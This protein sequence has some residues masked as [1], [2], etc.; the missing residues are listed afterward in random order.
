MDGYEPGHIGKTMEKVESKVKCSGCGSAYKL[1]IP[2][3][4]KPVNFKCKKCGKVLKI[5]AKGGSGNSERSPQSEPPPAPPPEPPPGSDL[6]DMDFGDGMP[7]FETSQLPDEPDYGGTG[8]SYQEPSQPPMYSGAISPGSSLDD[9]DDSFEAA[10]PPP[11]PPRKKQAAQLNVQTPG[12]ADPNQRWMVLADEEVLGPFSDA[13]VVSMIKS[14]DI[15]SDTSLRMGERPWIKAVQV[16]AFRDLFARSGASK[17]GALGDIQ[18]PDTISSEDQGPS[19]PEFYEDLSSIAPFPVTGTGA[20]AFGV[21]FGIAFVAMTALCFSFL[22]GLPISIIIWIILYGYLMTVLESGANGAKS[23]P[24][25]D[26]SA[27]KEIVTNG[28]NLFAILL[29]FSLA[30]L[31]ILLVLTLIFFLNYMSMLG[32]L[33]MLLSMVV[34]LGSMFV[35]PASLAL[36]GASGS[37]GIALNPSRVMGLIKKG[38]KAYSMLALISVGIGFLCMVMMIANL[39]LTDLPAIGF[40]VAGLLSALVFSYGHFIWFHVLGRFTGE[41]PDVTNQVMSGVLT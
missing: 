2:L 11:P 17:V 8:Q 32:Y 9:Q 27:M 6:P 31:A 30:P 18:M 4:D 38:G 10:Q 41:N 37:L 29:L 13:E 28:A 24:K 40:L 35:A 34:F 33:F 5:K 26:F 23:P 19:G 12:M 36:Y 15:E 16:A 20:Q 3:T 21:F 7:E 1:R 39:F 14:G 22:L 25:W